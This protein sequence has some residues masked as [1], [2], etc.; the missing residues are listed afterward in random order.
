MVSAEFRSADENTWR[1]QVTLAHAD[2]GWDHYADSWRIVDAS[3]KVLATRV[4]HHPHVNE[5][6]FTRG[7]DGVLIEDTNTPYYV[8]AHDKQHGWST[9]KLEVNLEQAIDGRLK[10]GSGSRGQ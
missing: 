10:V 8:E 5:Q 4:L 9:S 7:L 6:P 1:V 3:G 2:T